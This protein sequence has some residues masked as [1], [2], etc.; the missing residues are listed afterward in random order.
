MDD[1]TVKIS[2][3]SVASQTP[4]TN[5][6]SLTPSSI[7]FKGFDYLQ[8]TS[9]L[10]PENL[11]DV[12]ESGI[13][14]KYL[15]D[16][17]GSFVS[18]GPGKRIIDRFTCSVAGLEVLEGNGWNAI[19][20]KGETCTLLGNT[21]ILELLADLDARGERW[22]CSRVDFA[23]DGFPLSPKALH[24]H[25]EADNV[26][27][28]ARLNPDFQTNKTGDTCYT[29][30]KPEANG[31][32]RYVRC[33][34][35]RG[36]TR[37]ELVMKGKYAKELVASLV[38]CDEEQLHN[39]AMA[40]QRGFFDLLRPGSQRKDRRPL[41]A[42]WV[43]FIGDAEIWRPE[44]RAA[45]AERQGFEVLGYY[46][47]SIQRASRALCELLEAFGEEYV[48]ARLEKYGSEKVRPDRVEHL[49]SIRSGAAR[50]G[51]AGVTPW[52]SEIDSDSEE[53]PF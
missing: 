29:H 45:A 21:V 33:Y 11:L 8:V 30:V 4:P 18:R 53:V 41:L 25:L 51:I 17:V 48:I 47:G 28:R 44:A 14:N 19:R 46:E 35:M 36:P 2:G 12:L 37:F 50:K 1:N 42:A 26:L 49:K 22:Q 20:L 34:D 27:T 24:R 10:S 7:T 15:P 43:R 52:P 16:S 23:W 38:G 13:L 31:I 5:R 3:P 6:G 9:W 39:K 32:D 40:S